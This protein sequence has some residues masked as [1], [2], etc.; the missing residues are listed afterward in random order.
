MKVCYVDE[1]GNTAQD[2]CLVMV[3]ILVDAHRLNRTREEFVGIFDEIQGLF[4]ENLRELKASKMILG[5]DRWRKVDP[6]VRKRIAG[7]LCDWIAERKHY[8]ALSAI[9]RCKLKNDKTVNVP[10]VCRDEWLA[11]GLHIALQLQKA[12]QGTDK[13]KG[14]TFLIF[15]DNKAR[16]DALSDLLWQ[17]PEWTD[18]YYGK[19]KK[20]ARL[21]QIVDTTFSIKSHHAGLVQVAALCR[22]EGFRT[23]GR[24]ARR[25][26]L[27]RWLRDHADAATAA[28]QLP[29]ARTA[30]RS[31]VAVVQFDRADLADVFGE[32][33]MQNAK[34][35]IEVD[36][37]LEQVSLDSVHEKTAHAGHIKG[38]HSWPAR[39]PL[40]V[41]RAAL[42]AAL[43]S[44]PGSAE[45]RKAIY[46][47]LA[48][49]VVETIERKKVNGKIVEKRK[50][51]TRGGILHWG[52]ESGPDLD[53][54]RQKI[55]E[56][57][58]GR[59]PKVLDP[60][61]GG[62]AIPLEAM[63]LGCE[64]TAID[65][66]PVA[67]FI[68]KCTL[69]YPQKLA[70]Q[71]RPLPGF[72]LKDRDFM[73]G[74]LKAKG[75]KGV[76]LR[77]QLAKLGLDGTAEPELIAHDPLLNADLGWQVRAWGRWVLAEARKRLVHRYPTYAEFQALQAGGR[78]YE[79]RPLQLL[80][81]DDNGNTDVAL[82]NARFPKPYLDDPRNPRWVAKPTVA[83]LW[84]RTVR[85]K[86]CRATVPLLKTRWL[87]KKD[88][89]RV[90]LTMSPNPER[91]GVIFGIEKNVPMVGGNAAQRREHDKR[92]GAGTMTRSGAQCPYCPTIT[93]T[94]DIRLEG[95][96]RRLG[97]TLTVVVVDSTTGKEYRMPTEYEF[98][99]TE[100]SNDEIANA[101]T[102][103]PYGL[104]NEEI[105]VDRPSPN[106]RGL[107]GLPRYGF[108]KFSSLYKN[109]QL[110]AFA[111][112]IDGIRSIPSKLHD[113]DFT[114]G[115]V[116]YLTL[117]L[118]KLVDYNSTCVAWQPKGEKGANTFIR[119]ALPLTL[120]FCEN[121]IIGSSGGSFITILDWVARP[122]S[123]A[124]FEATKRAEVPDVIFG[125]ALKMDN[126]RYDI[127]ITDPPYYDAIPYSD[128]MDFFYV[129]LRRCSKKIVDVPEYFE[130]EPLCPKW[131]KESE[132]GELIDQ[133]S[134]FASDLVAS[135][136]NYESGMHNVFRHCA[137]I[138]D[139]NGVMIV[140]FANKQPNAW[141]ALAGALIRAGFIVDASW[142]IRTEMGNRT[143]AIATAS[144]SSSVWLVC[145]KRPPA[146]P[147]FDTTVLAEMRARIH[148]QLRSFWDAGIRGPDFVW[149]ATGPALE[150]FSKYPVVKK[151]DAPDGQMNI[152][153][154]LREVRRLVV[155]FVVGRVLSR[156]DTSEE[157]A[158]LDDVTTYYLLHRHDFSLGDA[159]I[160]ACIL[161][162]LSCNLSDSELA[163][164][165]DILVRTGGTLFDDLEDAEDS[166]DEE[167]PDVEDD[168]VGSGGKGNKVKLKAWNQ[169]RSKT[170]G[171]EAPGGRAVPLIDQ[172]HRLMHLWRAADQAK[173]DD[174][175]D[176]RGLK[177]NALFAHLLQALIELAGAGS[178]ERAILESLSN[179]IAAR[180]GI[181][182]P[183][184]AQLA[185]SA[186][187]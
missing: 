2:P 21:D 9:D 61:A 133:P 23:A 32:M 151:A 8:I 85:C 140:V 95:Q 119:W 160:G 35:L 3:G 84:A 155:D 59:A 62:G 110:L 107:S 137:D 6:E 157:A 15:D 81:P 44:D 102:G 138:L 17:P 29:L 45:E 52:R 40:A 98:T 43:L 163:D 58:G 64:A 30:E 51:E 186:E 158:S 42:V 139:D 152:S 125:S 111:A 182:A 120:D 103:I 124:L 60:F 80:E 46:R 97:T 136:T 22:D 18:D 12:N 53:W 86:G 174:Y 28:A 99:M 11:G 171:L 79:S 164:R 83:Y 150:A 117:C 20:Q 114:T 16:A 179:H 118:G 172:A 90:L 108:D 145:K 154:F 74:F 146:R 170:L 142:P 73:G 175:L 116:A 13:N 70:G 31:I 26:G 76:G 134:R 162:A 141:E 127:V 47:R 106:T 159:P 89:K 131:N 48:G 185:L 68:L 115:I 50:R 69:E 94:E 178:E 168:D 100:P 39:R 19:Q 121:N 180:G 25:T 24:M 67:W 96:A 38:I 72:A 56:A 173:V 169:R 128:L 49:E 87:A 1:T 41:S 113:N 10:K 92:K 57:Y 167:Q 105:S 5:R 177:R 147:G 112:I 36:F 88:N 14:H 166:G 82:L 130:L 153:E 101:Y 33:T 132:D 34:R 104:P 37:P 144:L 71:T 123:E 7:Y 63:R 4:E 187:P 183:R 156:E 148:T 126:R 54:F 129:W 135:R 161:Y 181:A 91:T 149:A 176:A 75:F 55:R 122:V 165:F 65:I 184:Q 109:R 143:N 93:T 27:D 77:R 78:P 66:N